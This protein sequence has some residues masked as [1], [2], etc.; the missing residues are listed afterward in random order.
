MSALQP[1]TFAA[2][3]FLKTVYPA[4]PWALTAIN[5][6]RKGI[7]TQT[8]FPTP[9]G[10]TQL[11]KWLGYHNGKS[12]L[13]WHVNPVRQP[14]FKKAERED[15]KEVC[16]LHVDVDPA[17]GKD[18]SVERARILDK[19]KSE[20]SL[21][22]ATFIIYSGGGY[23]AFWKLKTP[24][25]INGDLARAEEA[26]RYNLQLELIFGADNVHNIDRIMRLPGTIN[27][28]DAKKRK[29]GRVA[30]LAQVVEVN[31]DRS[32]DLSM[33][34]PAPLVQF[35][36]E[37]GFTSENKVKLSG[38]V[39]RL[40]SVEDL[41]DYGVPDRVKVI[42]VQ[43]CLPD[44]PKQG[45]NSRSA[46]LF[47]CVCNLVRCKVPDDVIFSVITDRD[48]G[49]SASVLDAGANAEKYAI[50]QI[51]RAKEEAVDPWL[52]RLN[53]RY[54]VIGNIGGK[55]RVIEEVN[56]PALN[57][58][59]LTR[60]SFEDFC[61]RYMNQYIQL[62]TDKEGKPLMAPVG[63]WW[64][65]HPERKQYDTIVFA[66]GRETPGCYNLW[67]GFACEA[68]P[69]ECS[70]YLT[71]V[72]TNICGGNEA[73]YTYLI[74]WMARAVQRP[75]SPGQTAVV[76]RGKQGTGKSIFVKTFGSLFGRHFMQVADPKHLVGSFNA[77]LRDTVVLFGDEAFYAGDKKHESVLK[78]LIT[79]EVITVESKGVDAEASPNY[80]HVLLASNSQWIVPAGADERRYFVLDV[81]DGSKQDS[82]YFQKIV[83]EMN[84]GGRQALLYFLLNYNLEGFQ[85]RNVPKTEALHEQK[86]LSLSPEEEW[87]YRKLDEGRLLPDHE[88]WE[89]RVMKHEVVED[90]LD[91]MRSM[92]ISRRSNETVLG[93]FLHRM[94]P[95]LGSSQSRATFRVAAG[96]EGWT[97]EVKRRVYFFELPTLNACR[98]RWQELYGGKS[99][100][101]VEPLSQPALEQQPEAVGVM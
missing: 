50:R 66:P 79:E 96:A 82:V 91:Y 93:K 81:G 67:K 78:M 25:P 1:D 94:C 45:D 53:E 43:G 64:L 27:L 6:D 83:D 72:R 21:P 56:D 59:R 15:I 42:I 71:H 75:D 65:K 12:N 22:S 47:D 46:W 57:R 97:K 33:F 100:A 76:L 30:A 51:E 70:L 73:Y 32:Y 8:F 37:K 16:Y 3:S 44:E 68:K 31:I 4:G 101:E 26:K 17:E 40:N 88:H 36:G 55:C 84:S 18:L 11:S 14:V 48:F 77:H 98:N 19:L 69:G 52:R 92:N 34:T 87:W 20:K 10:L 2:I 54:A 29:K 74:S 39:Q 60:Q 63:K 5:P 89:R 62:G 7:E 9:D 95:G 58:S 24:I 61:N 90:Y 23:Q 49:I 38:N 13:Y 86:L 35:A 85:V 41:N 99:F 80:T 28:P